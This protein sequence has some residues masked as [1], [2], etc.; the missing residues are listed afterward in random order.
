M[1]AHHK[2]SKKRLYYRS[3]IRR[4]ILVKGI[5]PIPTLFCAVKGGVVDPFEAVYVNYPF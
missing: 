1:A 2:Q 3:Y 5:Q 4:N